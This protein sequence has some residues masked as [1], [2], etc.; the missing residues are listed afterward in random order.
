[1]LS[2]NNHF[3]IHAHRRGAEDAEDRS[4]KNGYFDAKEGLLFGGLSPPNKKIISLRPLR[5]C[6]EISILNKND[7]ISVIYL[8]PPLRT[9][10]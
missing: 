5:L 7:P 1:M 3:Q 9:A 10:I 8:R 4:A 2:I 6:G